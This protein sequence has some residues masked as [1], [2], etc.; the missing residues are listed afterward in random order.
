[1]DK[2]IYS[3]LTAV[4]WP[5]VDIN[6]TVLRMDICRFIGRGEYIIIY[7]SHI[8]RRTQYYTLVIYIYKTITCCCLSYETKTCV[9]SPES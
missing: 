7:V 2:P 1:M 8:V 9:V 3:H 6:E 5:Q 4:C